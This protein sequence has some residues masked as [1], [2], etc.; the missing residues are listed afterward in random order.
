M[1]LSAVADTRLLLTLKFPPS[2]DV[3]D[4]VR[5]RLHAELR[6]GFVIPSI[7]VTE[8]LK[9]AGQR[10]GGEAALAHLSELETSGATVVPVDREVAVRAGR[11]L[12]AHPNV[13]VADALVAATAQVWR[14]ESVLSD[15][16]HFRVLGMKTRWL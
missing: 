1:A 13:P 9:I 5:V 6:R 12:L 2:P 4:K 15:D 11:L 16:P 8:Y 3:R 7:V 10:I 14:A